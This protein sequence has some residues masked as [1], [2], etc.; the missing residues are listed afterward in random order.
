MSGPWLPKR[1]LGQQIK[2]I[3]EV[4]LKQSQPT[5]AEALGR[6]RSDQGAVSTWERGDAYPPDETI[7]E[8]ARVAGVPLSRFM[9]LPDTEDREIGEMLVAAK[10]MDKMAAELRERATD[11]SEN[12]GTDGWDRDMD[13][14]GPPEGDSDS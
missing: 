9:E 2:E 12:D 11:L 6:P 10:W 4:Q 8:I 1:E 13:L 7:V 14:G 3:R 5:F